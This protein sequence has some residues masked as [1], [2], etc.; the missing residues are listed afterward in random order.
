MLEKNHKFNASSI[1]VRP[2]SA[3]TPYRSRT[4]INMLRGLISTND[5]KKGID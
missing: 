5:W 4:S 2:I 3:L 1:V